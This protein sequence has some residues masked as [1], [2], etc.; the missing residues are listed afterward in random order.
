MSFPPYLP[1]IASIDSNIQHQYNP[2]TNMTNTLPP[3]IAII[4]A[5]L[6]GLSLLAHLQRHGISATMYERDASFD[7]RNELGSMLDMHY[8]SGQRAMNEAGIQWKHLIMPGCE[9]TRIYN[10]K[11]ELQYSDD[12]THGMHPLSSHQLT[13]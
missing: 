6:G 5:G 13:F 11:G 8:E 3:R 9:E 2:L 1:K 10:S 4:G 12:G 7:A